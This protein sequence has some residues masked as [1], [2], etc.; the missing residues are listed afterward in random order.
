M[1]R[2]FSIKLIIRIFLLLVTI[3]TF[4]FIFGDERLFFNHI[5]LIA[6]IIIQVAELIHFVN[7][8]NR[9][10]SRLFLAI[11]HADFSTSYNQA[12]LGRSFRELQDSLTEIIKAYKD[13]KTE[14]EVQYQFLQ[15]LINQ[16]H[17]GIISLENKTDIVLINP[18]A[19]QLLNLQGIKNWKLAAQL[20]P[21]FVSEVEQLGDNGR[22]LITLPLRDDT[23][24]LSVDV[25]T[26]LTPETPVKLITFQDI[27]AEIQQKE[28]EAWNKLVRILTHEI[29]NSIT[30]ISSLTETMQ[31]MLEDRDGRQKKR[32]ELTDENIHDVLFSLKTIQRRS[33]SL[34]DFVDSYR[35]VTRVPKP[36]PELINVGELFGSVEK[37][38]IKP[39][40]K[41]NIVLTKQISPDATQVLLDPVLIEQVLINLVTNS[42]HALEGRP[43]P[44]IKLK[45]YKDGS[46]LVLEVTDNGKGIPEK[47]LDE[48]FIPFFSTK[49]EGSGIGLSLSK[50]IISSHNGNIRV[51]SEVNRGT[52][53]FLSFK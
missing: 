53:F 11:R 5:I 38:M 15:M 12:S 14:K 25:R 48:I 27:N 28:I 39:L 1:L 6:I 33:N 24:M 52:S 29:M 2:R 50:Q 13:V 4:A 8:T 49:K 46:K 17:V 3:T 32:D 16:I 44:V 31:S 47:E 51:K 19:E 45:S 41:N 35:Q 43:D 30:P 10:L 37:L 36:S 21:S 26:L 18:V 9:E 20:N 42:I 7:R 22:K 34:L 40:A 23:Q